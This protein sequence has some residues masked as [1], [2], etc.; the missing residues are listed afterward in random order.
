MNAHPLPKKLTLTLLRVKG[1]KIQTAPWTTVNYSHILGAEHS[2]F[3]ELESHD[4]YVDNEHAQIYVDEGHWC[5]KNLSERLNLTLDG[6]LLLQNT[7]HLLIH[8]SLLELGLCQIQITDHQQ[9]EATQALQKVLLLDANGEEKISLQP[10]NNLMLS[11]SQ[12]NQKL[13]IATEILAEKTTFEDMGL[14]I[15]FNEQQF[16][17][18]IQSETAQIRTLQ[19]TADKDSLDILDQLAIES[20]LAIINPALLNKDIDYWQHNAQNLDPEKNISELDHLFALKNQHGDYM[21]PLDNLEQINDLLVNRDNIDKMIGRLDA[22]DQYALFDGEQRIEPLRLFSLENHD[23]RD[24]VVQST[25]RFTQKEHHSS[26]MDSYF[27]IQSTA[28]KASDSQ[29]KN[30]EKAEDKHNWLNDFSASLNDKVSA[31]DILD[32]LTNNPQRK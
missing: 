6:K 3:S 18:E 10:H 27:N 19:A 29:P 14:G 20:E 24:Y 17:K 9:V 13:A 32:S 21:V 16:F 15:H 23:I 30:R 25:P 28:K 8:N 5:V 2:L 11:D 26:S 31:D 1:K 4:I 7:R 22:V 12:K